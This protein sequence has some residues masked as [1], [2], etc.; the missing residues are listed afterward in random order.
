M[1]HIFYIISLTLYYGFARYLP[2]SNMLILGKISKIT[3]A[4]LVKRI[5]KYCGCKVNIEPKVYGA[6]S[7]V[8]KE[9]PDHAIV[10]GNPAKIIK[11]R[12]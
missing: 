1:K 5:F 12:E 2:H 4:L 8:T 3:R 10:G 9:V 7:V 6:V 11:Y